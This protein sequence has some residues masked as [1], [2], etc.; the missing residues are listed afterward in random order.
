MHKIVIEMDDKANLKISHSA[1][2]NLPG[3]TEILLQ[4]LLFYMRHFLKAAPKSQRK[5]FKKQAYD[6]VNYKCSAVLENFAP[7]FE[8]RPS[9]SQEAIMKAENEILEDE[10]S[11]MQKS[12]AGN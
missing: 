10:L 2:L 7:D 8:L 12:D 3:V 11:K 9:L 4:A 5:E 1:G 6:M